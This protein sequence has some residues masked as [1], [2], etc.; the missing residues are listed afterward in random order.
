MN[1]IVNSFQFL[2]NF[3][4]PLRCHTT[5]CG[6]TAPDIFVLKIMLLKKYYKKRILSK[7]GV[8]TKRKFKKSAASNRLAYE[9]AVKL[10]LFELPSI[11]IDLVEKFTKT[12]QCIYIK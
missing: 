6:T 2:V 3:L 5:L 7:A 11:K 4:S 8:L 9:S 12:H 10:F 1:I